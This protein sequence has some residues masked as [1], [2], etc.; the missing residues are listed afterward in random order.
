MFLY[1]FLTGVDDA[2]FCARVEKLLNE[3]WV[4]HGPPVLTFDGVRMR[5][6]QAITCE[7]SGSYGG[8]VPLD[9]MYP[10]HGR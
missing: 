2:A 4:L 9:T 6:G 5:A 8:F 3:G 1:R 10:E 7:R